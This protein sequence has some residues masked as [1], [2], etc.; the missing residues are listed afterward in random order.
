MCKAVAMQ[1]LGPEYR[2]MEQ[3]QKRMQWQDS[4]FPAPL[5]GGG[6]GCVL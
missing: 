6:G 1:M 5:E 3:T 2:L 4:V